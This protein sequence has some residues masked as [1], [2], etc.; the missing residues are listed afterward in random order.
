[1]DAVL[2]ERGYRRARYAD[3]FVMLR[4][5]REEVGAALEGVRAWVSGT[6]LT[7]P[8][9]RRMS[10][11]AGSRDKGLSSSATGSKPASVACARRA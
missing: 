1:M 3:D 9:R 2:G 8:P 11:T 6:G 7:L 10:A 5:T 4:R